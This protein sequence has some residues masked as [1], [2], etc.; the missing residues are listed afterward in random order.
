MSA[1]LCRPL[2]SQGNAQVGDRMTLTRATSGGA[3][4]TSEAATIDRFAT[5]VEASQ[6]VWLSRFAA[7]AE[8]EVRTRNTV[9]RIAVIEGGR[10]RVRGGSCFPGWTE[11]FLA[12][13][14][15]GGGLLKMA[16]V[17]RGFCMEFLHH[18][19]R[20]VTT[21]VREIVLPIGRDT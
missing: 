2:G 8:F 18:G 5:A 17:G 10:V 7:R 21:R 13:S 9:Y 15:L 4:A 1:H 20:V 12:G 14:T 11:A 6:G 19:Q 3:P 16:W